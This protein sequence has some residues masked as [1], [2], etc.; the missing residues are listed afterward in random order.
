MVGFNGSSKTRE[1]V[2]NPS[3]ASDNEADGE[4]ALDFIVVEVEVEVVD[5]SFFDNGKSSGEDNG[6]L[7]EV[8]VDVDCENEGLVKVGEGQGLLRLFCSCVVI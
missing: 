8:A 3:I 2:D 5:F 1:F 4:I 6:E 7:V